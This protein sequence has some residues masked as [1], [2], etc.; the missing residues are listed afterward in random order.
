VAVN[1]LFYTVKLSS[2]LVKEYKY[3]I[4]L[5]FTDCLKAGLIVSLAD[6]QM[7][8]TIR[9]ITS[10]EIDREQL[11]EWYK[12]RDRLKK[13]K[14]NTAG[15]RKRIKELQNLIYEMMYIP[16]YITVSM[17]SVAD[18]KHM[19]EKGF[20]FNGEMYKRASCSASQARVST[21]VFVKESILPEL[22]KRLNNGRDESH[23]L[24]PSKYNAYF[25][26]YSSASKKVTKPRFC[27]VPD[28]CEDM[29]IE[30]SWSIENP[31]W[32]KDDTIEDRKISNEFNRFDGSGLISPEMAKQWGEDIGED[33]TPCQFCIRTSFTKGLVNEFDFVEWCRDELEGIK[34]EEEKYLIKDIYGQIRDL[35]EVDVIIS[36]GMAKLWDSWISQEEYERCC[37]E[38]GID[39][40][41]TKYA[42]KQDKEAGLLNYQYL[43]TLTDE[44]DIEA[45]CK[46]TVDYVQGVSLD[47]VYYTLLFC[48]GQGMDEEEIQQYM[49]SSDNYWIKCLILDHGLLNDKYTKEKIRD[50]IVTRIEQACLGRLLVQGNYQAIVPDSYAF[51]QWI[52]G[53][54]VT[55]LLEDGEFYSQFW[56]KR[57]IDKI[58]C[59][60]SPMTYRSEWCIV[61]NKYKVDTNNNFK[62]E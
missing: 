41:V 47:D 25:G 61:E 5:T 32:D 57:G 36:E 51:M 30:V 18:Y 12:E 37:E 20:M 55:G 53:Q 24:A 17:E 40:R 38:N 9:D 8:K 6:S 52:T 7:L 15:K 60:R 46:D 1:R 56:E 16:G 35:R 62:E 19:F 2:S 44:V 10:Q 29:D 58:A 23:P 3:N 28:Y 45:I 14:S 48:L 54:E 27:I 31:D 11:E 39:W 43:Q 34:P 49:K 33:Y 13:S 42:P 26:L 22:K 4:N 50:M 59:A 21:I